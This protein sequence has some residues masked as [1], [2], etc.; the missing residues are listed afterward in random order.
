MR[1]G[2]DVSDTKEQRCIDTKAVV[3]R[4]RE[5]ANSES[6]RLVPQGSG[7]EKRMS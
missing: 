6:G 4:T 7:L 2:R 1:C 5:A 3:R